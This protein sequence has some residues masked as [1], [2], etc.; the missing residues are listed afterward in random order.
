V[1]WT[2]RSMSDMDAPFTADEIRAAHARNGIEDAAAA[3]ARLAELW[4]ETVDREFA[5]FAADRARWEAD[6]RRRRQRV[7]QAQEWLR[8]NPD[9][10]PTNT[11]TP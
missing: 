10:A 11:E 1:N 8:A 7:R 9:A 6:T 5:R 2:P 3:F 4:H